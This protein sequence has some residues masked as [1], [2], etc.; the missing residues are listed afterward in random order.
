MR[1]PGSRSAVGGAS[2][3]PKYVAL[4]RRDQHRLRHRFAGVDQAHLR[5][6]VVVR[7]DDD[8]AMALGGV[9]SD[10]E[11]RIRLLVDERI[12]AGRRAEAVP[13]DTRRPVV[14]VEDGV[15]ERLAVRCPGREIG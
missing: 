14:V 2:V 13:V 12:V 8:E 5:R 3:P 9:N 7:V 10:E 11:A 1:F 15:E 4:S 6:R